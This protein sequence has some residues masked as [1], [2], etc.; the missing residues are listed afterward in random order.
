MIWRTLFIMTNL[1]A[2]I[3]LLRLHQWTKN[4][5]IFA[6]LVF[7]KNL[8]VPDVATTALI[9]FI[10]FCF[11]SSAAYV[12]NDITDR[13]ADRHHP[14]K[15]ERPLAAGTISVPAALALAAVLFVVAFAVTMTLNVK[16]QLIV[17]SYLILQVL[18][19]WKLKKIPLVDIF[20]IAT[21]FMLRVVAGAFVIDVL[22]S[23]WLILCTLFV[24]IFL[25]LSKRRG[26]ML[27][28]YSTEGFEGRAVLREYDMGLIDQFI[29]VA[30][31]GMTISYA[32]YTVAERTVR[33][34]QTDNL[35]LT[36][37]FVLFGTFRFLT[38]MKNR[39]S[40][41]NPTLLLLTDRVMLINMVLW[42]VSC[43]LMIYQHELQTYLFP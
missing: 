34:F 27:L 40:E 17:L 10:A 1:K 6:A 19:S 32:L 16:F 29:T 9:A 15:R 21:G 43:V 28:T 41:D 8:F 20:V 35:I 26:E 37:P 31:S 42:F 30:A 11:L 3:K 18:Y 7:S 33:T 36:T 22:L 14:K 25:A 23:H 39:A 4:M 2:Y 12:V 38:N 5:F 13:E 24:S